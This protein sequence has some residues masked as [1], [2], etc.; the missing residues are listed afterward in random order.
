VPGIRDTGPPFLIGLTLSGFV[1]ETL[2]IVVAPRRYGGTIAKIEM[3]SAVSFRNADRK[4]V[5]NKS[6]KNLSTTFYLPDKYT[7]HSGG[8]S[9]REDVCS[10]TNTQHVTTG[11]GVTLSAT[12]RPRSWI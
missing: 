1:F 2:T 11:D 4:N 6:I 8:K 10:L 5:S 7:R 3:G 9:C 12:Q